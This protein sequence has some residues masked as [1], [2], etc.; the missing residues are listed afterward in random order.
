MRAVCGEGW[1]G[2]THNTAKLAGFKPAR[3]QR[4]G[5][6][7][8]QLTA[9]NFSPTARPMVGSDARVPRTARADGGAK[10]EAAMETAEIIP[11]RECVSPDPFV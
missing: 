8:R 7:R 4:Q 1:L 3:F 10:D 2:E 6:S 9:G 11:E 5:S